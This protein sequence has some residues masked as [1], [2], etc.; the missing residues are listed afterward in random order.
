MVELNE[1]YSRDMGTWNS[2]AKTYETQIVNGH[3]D[4]TAYE[5]FEED[6]L[7]RLLVTLTRDHG[8]HA[9]IYDFGCGS[10][11]L[12]ITLGRKSILAKSGNKDSAHSTGNLRN[13]GSIVHIGG[14]D[15]S[16][17]MIILAR[18]KA[19][20]QGL[21]HLIPKSLSYDVGSAFEVPSYE[22]E[23]TPVAVS[24]CNSVGVMQGP[25]GAQLLFETM[26]RYVEKKKGMAIISGYKKEALKDFGLGNYE[27]TLDV[28]GQPVW[29][30]PDTYSSRDYHL[31]SHYYKRAFDT[32]D[33][34]VVDVFDKDHKKLETGF[35]LYRDPD[36]TKET[37][38]TGIIKTYQDY[39][40][41][42]YGS[43]QFKQWVSEL[44]G[45]VPSWYVD[46]SKIDSLRGTPAQMAVLDFTGAFKNFANH[47]NIEQIG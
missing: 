43:D 45:D 6:L 16:E 23:N 20:K 40:S 24:V 25:E 8:R 11:R 30:K 5:E 18:Q 14:I 31:I 35:T 41:R 19:A 37:L 9:H 17:E 15:F 29:L 10:G 7:D 34:I 42:W 32:S 44:W 33:T 12:H 46:C 36:S 2:C 13:G 38:E 39:N 3:P 28:C 47:W 21:S 27:S 26:R 22:G 4:V 1:L